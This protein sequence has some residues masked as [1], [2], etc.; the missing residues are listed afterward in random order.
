MFGRIKSSVDY[1]GKLLRRTKKGDHLFNNWIQ[2]GAIDLH[3][4]DKVVGTVQLERHHD[5]NYELEYFVEASQDAFNLIISIFFTFP[6]N[7][8]NTG[9]HVVTR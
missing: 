9:I 7:T 6:T 5:M 2:L 3:G 4:I 1:G 8:F